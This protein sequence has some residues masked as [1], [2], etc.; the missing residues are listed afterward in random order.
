MKCEVGSMRDHQTSRR[1]ECRHRLA[2]VTKS[3]T[4]L[5][6]C[7]LCVLTLTACVSS[8][9]NGSNPSGPIKVGVMASLSGPSGAYGPPIED[10]AKLAVDRINAAGGVLG[11]QVQLEIGDDAGDV[12][13]GT[14]TASRLISKEK[15]AVLVSME[16][17]NIRDAI[18][19]DVNR[20]GALYMYAP[21]YEG[22]ACASNM[23]LL[24]EVPADYK[25]LFP[26]V[27]QNLGGGNWYFVG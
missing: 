16:G 19:P 10:A 1:R 14:V 9:N 22:G 17:S 26:Y 23:Y 18:V 20:T 13:T 11:Q 3:T 25:P 12:K 21:L 5:S 24:G 4:C 27:N 15:V 7:L 2:P 6:V 8:S